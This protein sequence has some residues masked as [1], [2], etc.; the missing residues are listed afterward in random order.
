MRAISNVMKVMLCGFSF[1]MSSLPNVFSQ[2][3]P[4]SMDTVPLEMPTVGSNTLRVIS[5]TLLELVLINT[6]QPDPAQFTVWNFVDS[7]GALQLP[8]VSQFVVTAGG[9]SASSCL[10]RPAAMSMFSHECCSGR[11]K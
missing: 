9:R 2:S 7:S 6:K 1:L 4:P 3:Q 10:S 11:W 5:P 8:A